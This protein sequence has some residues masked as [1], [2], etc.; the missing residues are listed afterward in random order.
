MFAA[1]KQ[2][3][4]IINCILFCNHSDKLRLHIRVTKENSLYEIIRT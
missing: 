3:K 1:L 2:T 4:K